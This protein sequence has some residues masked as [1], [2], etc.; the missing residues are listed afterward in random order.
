[1]EFLW[2]GLEQTFNI[3]T[4][5]IIAGSVFL[6]IFFGAI[7][8]LTAS[9]GIAL[10]LPFTFGLG[11]VNGLA[12]LLG[13]YVGAT[14]GGMISATLIGIPG[15]G[16]SIVTTFD[17]YP[18]AQ[19]GKANHALSLGVFASLVGGIISMI[20][21]TFISPLL[22][23]VA[24]MF[25]PWEYF[26]LGIF[27]LTIVVSV[28]SE[29]M[30]KGLIAACIG[31][32][33]TMFGQD[34]VVATPRFTFGFAQLEGGFSLLPTLLGFFAISRFFMDVNSTDKSTA[35]IKLDKKYNI[36]PSLKI[37]KSSIGNLIRSSFIG[38]WIGILPGAG[39]SIASFL[40]YDRAR[41][42]SK[43][44]E[45][46]GTGHDEGVIASESS[47]NAVTGGALIPLMTL[48]IPGDMVT[49]VILGGLLI[50]GLQPGPMLFSNNAEIVGSIF[51]GLL[52]ATI[53]MFIIQ[54]GL[55]RYF[56]RIIQVPKH[57]L[58]PI[59]IVMSM[60]GTFSANNRIFDLWVLIIFGLIGYILILNKFDLAPL[61]LGYIL[62]P[63]IEQNW[64][65]GLMVTGGEVLPFVTR[66]LSLLLLVVAALSILYPIFKKKRTVEKQK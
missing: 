57:I 61:I 52:F 19:Q 17:G 27:G 23:E 20:L 6:G 24:L 35:T 3:Y 29:N 8:G 30:L 47:N 49:A 39:G 44:P 36:F 56:A 48:G 63:I 1:M 51:I 38:T 25:G 18:M 28:S 37:I 11:P 21:L 50:H 10:L 15:T 32:F 65:L 5:L 40:S 7:P 22:A 33:I 55:M 58:L 60:V 9:L 59:I 4:I 54:S 14:S 2:I 46:F 42:A 62:G 13:M 26:A 16:A 53:L 66:P 34:P 31:V 12:A 43:T 64:R 45:K 41:K